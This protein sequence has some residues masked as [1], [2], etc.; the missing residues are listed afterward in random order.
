MPHGRAPS[1]GNRREFE[2]RDPS[3]RRRPHETG[4][5][6]LTSGAIQGGQQHSRRQS[7]A[8]HDRER[9]IRRTHAAVNPTKAPRSRSPTRARA[10]P[11][12]RQ[13]ETGRPLRSALAASSSNSRRR[14]QSPRPTN[15][16]NS[17]ALRGACVDRQASR[18]RKGYDTRRAD[19]SRTCDREDFT[20]AAHVH[21][22]SGTMDAAP[23][24]RSRRPLY[25]P[26]PEH[27]DRSTPAQSRR[28]CR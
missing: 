20:R 23:I 18:I 14:D 9:K 16:A 27:A 1:Q 25:Q 22:L 8:L 24:V 19:A 3:A 4:A 11:K 26:R 15:E 12:L 5:Q 17:T 13:K 7:D 6:L 21:A 2:P 28:R 10:R